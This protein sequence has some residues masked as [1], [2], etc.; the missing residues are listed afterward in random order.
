MAGFTIVYSALLFGMTLAISGNPTQDPARDPVLGQATSQGC[1]GQLPSTSNLKETNTF[2][3]VGTCANRCQNAGK[4]VAI[5]QM[6]KCYC[7]GTYPSRRA[8][9]TDTTCDAPCPG[10]ALQACG[11]AKG[12]YGVLN[13]GLEINVQYDDEEAD[14]VTTT[15]DD[16]VPRTGTR[17][18]FEQITA[19]VSD[20]ASSTILDTGESSASSL[21]STSPTKIET[22]KP[23]STPP[24]MASTSADSDSSTTG[25]SAPAATSIAT[26]TSPGSVA[27]SS[28]FL[29]LNNFASQFAAVIGILFMMMN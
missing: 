13:T 3:S 24:T 2:N 10:Y 17:T 28:K 22:P 1:F 8:L 25:S 7:A 23:S 19:D 4:A 9:V 20:S 14:P 15:S 12:A 29:D 18:T 6:S 11:G 5:V 16:S 26:V 21:A 27:S